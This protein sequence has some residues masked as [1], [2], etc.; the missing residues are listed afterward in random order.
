M[1]QKIFTCFVILGNSNTERDQI[2]AKNQWLKVY[3]L[4]D[5]FFCR[6]KLKASIKSEQWINHV[7]KIDKKGWRVKIKGIPT[8]GIQKWSKKANGK[9]CTEQMEKHFDLIDLAQSNG[10]E[11]YEFIEE[12]FPEINQYYQ[13]HET[14]IDAYLDHDVNIKHQYAGDFHLWIRKS[15]YPNKFWNQEISFWISESLGLQSEKELLNLIK[16]INKVAY[17]VKVAKAKFYDQVNED[18]S[19]YSR[20]GSM[21]GDSKGLELE[22]DQKVQISPWEELKI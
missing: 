21:L 2:Y 9:V 19:V 3:N 15:L 11:W 10:L 5:N 17:G 6:Y 22:V 14:R 7:K 20:F 8:G 16:E 18:S 1:K 13:F 4:L 12:K